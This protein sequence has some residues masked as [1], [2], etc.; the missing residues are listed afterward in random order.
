MNGWI[1][2]VSF[3]EKNDPF[4][5]SSRIIVACE[6]CGVGWRNLKICSEFEIQCGLGAEG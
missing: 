5:P 2:L 3:P 6:R 4:S 1:L